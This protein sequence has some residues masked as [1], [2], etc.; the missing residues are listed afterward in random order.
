MPAN[1]VPDLEVMA[2]ASE[3]D[4]RDAYFCNVP[5]ERMDPDAV[6]GGE[7]GGR[8]VPRAT[9]PVPSLGRKRIEV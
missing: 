8:T 4:R 5:R 7:V 6:A 2:L 1:G 3:L 9:L